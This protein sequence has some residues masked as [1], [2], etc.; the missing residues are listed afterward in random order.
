MSICPSVYMSVCIVMHVCLYVRRCCIPSTI[1]SFHPR[2]IWKVRHTTLCEMTDQSTSY[3]PAYWESNL[4]LNV[5]TALRRLFRREA[6]NMDSLERTIDFT[7]YETYSERALRT[8]QD[9]RQRALIRG[10]REQETPRLS[11]RSHRL[12]LSDDL[13]R[14]TLTNWQTRVTSRPPLW[15]TTATK[16]FYVQQPSVPEKHDYATNKHQVLREMR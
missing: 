16:P 4:L 2:R 13:V 8:L 5:L 1:Q 7:Y 11:P 14:P 12:K 6:F 9:S 10:N 15:H 3:L